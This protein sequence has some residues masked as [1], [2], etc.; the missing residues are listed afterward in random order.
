MW[1][2]LEDFQGRGEEVLEEP[3]TPVQNKKSQS[4]EDINVKYQEDKSWSQTAYFT[5]RL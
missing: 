4:Q 5:L 1:T 3:A 2:S